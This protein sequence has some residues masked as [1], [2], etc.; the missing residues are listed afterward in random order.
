MT[1]KH[2]TSH[3]AASKDK[4]APVV[5]VKPKAAPTAKR[6]AAPAVKPGGHG[7]G[8]STADHQKHGKHD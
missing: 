3:H 6:G 1:S 2:D 4:A 7:D 5:A 8:H